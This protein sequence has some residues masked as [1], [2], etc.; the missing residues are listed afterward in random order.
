MPHELRTRILNDDLMIFCTCHNFIRLFRLNKNMKEAIEC[1]KVHK[2][3]W[4]EEAKREEL[5]ETVVEEIHSG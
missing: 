5:A 3:A 4:D 2:W 1:W